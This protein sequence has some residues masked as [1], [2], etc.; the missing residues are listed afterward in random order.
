[1]G[2]FCLG[3]RSLICGDTNDGSG[4]DKKLWDSYFEAD[5]ANISLPVPVRVMGL[6]PWAQR[7]VLRWKVIG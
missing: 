2:C 3:L 1:M 7:F 5:Q 4:W 6:W